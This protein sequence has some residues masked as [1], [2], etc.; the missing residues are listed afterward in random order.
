MPLYL[1][2]CCSQILGSLHWLTE[3]ADD[4]V[5]IWEIN[6]M[7]HHSLIDIRQITQLIM[8]SGSLRGLWRA[9]RIPFTHQEQLVLSRSLHCCDRGQLMKQLTCVEYKH[10]ASRLKF[11]RISAVQ[12]VTVQPRRHN[13]TARY[14]MLLQIILCLRTVGLLSCRTVVC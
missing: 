12:I 2:G 7:V 6:C 4:A 14:V 5:L 10:P 8:I 13:S 11:T 1:T 3:L 9:C